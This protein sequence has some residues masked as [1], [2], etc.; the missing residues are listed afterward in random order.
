MN[1]PTIAFFCAAAVVVA[2]S[3]GVSCAV[4][5][6]H[7]AALSV[8]EPPQQRG[9][10]G[11]VTDRELHKV[12]EYPQK[13]GRLVSPFL[14]EHPTREQAKAAAV[15]ATPQKREGER[16]GRMVSAPK[17]KEIRLVGIVSS[18]TGRRAILS[19]GKQQIILAA[20][21]EKDNVTMVSLTEDS[22][23]VSTPS[24]ERTLSMR[25]GGLK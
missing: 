9:T 11:N 3:A 15:A 5:P 25:A 10:T 20:G 1:R 14:P 17:E 7:E 24:G 19:V 6:D 16:P 2:L 22:A 21:E 12:R 13:K 23:T 8:T 18:E 4:V